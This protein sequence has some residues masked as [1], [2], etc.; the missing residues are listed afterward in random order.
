MTVSAR[1]E[2]TLHA[3]RIRQLV[4]VARG[5]PNP[6]HVR[7]HM[8]DALALHLPAALADPFEQAGASNDDVVWR[9]RRLELDVSVNA[10]WDAPQLARA[11]A[12]QLARA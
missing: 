5:H 6:E 12:A 3:R 10:A 1:P 11:W 2:G 4:L 9:I 8:H 7:R